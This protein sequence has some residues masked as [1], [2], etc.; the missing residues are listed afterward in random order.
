MLWVCNYHF[1]IIR[2]DM[3]LSI[4]D[5]SLVVILFYQY[6]HIAW[7][8]VAADTRCHLSSQGRF[9]ADTVAVQLLVSCPDVKSC[10]LDCTTSVTIS[11]SVPDNID[12]GYIS[13]LET[14]KTA[15]AIRLASKTQ[16]TED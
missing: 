7:V 2:I 12:R 1:N 14:Q 5:K 11:S 6:R 3:R 16:N 15:A 9:S 8:D 13:T 4:I 10:T